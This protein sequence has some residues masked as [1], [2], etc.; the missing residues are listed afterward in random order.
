MPR[1]PGSEAAEPPPP[2]GRGWPPARR[3]ML[4]IWLLGDPHPSLQTAHG[5]GPW[6]FSVL[7]VS[8]MPHVSILWAC[9]EPRMLPTPQKATARLYH[10]QVRALFGTVLWRHCCWWSVTGSTPSVLR[11]AGAVWLN[12]G[13]GSA[14]RRMPLT[15]LSIS[16]CSLMTAGKATLRRPVTRGL[17]ALLCGSVV[18]TLAGGAFD[19][20]PPVRK[21]G[22][23]SGQRKSAP[24]PV[25][26]AEI[27]WACKEVCGNGH[28]GL[29]ITSWLPSGATWCCGD[30]HQPVRALVSGAAVLL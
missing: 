20:A 1:R 24:P 28:L 30:E 23:N 10:C 15:S 17:S 9:A 25:L 19:R 5:L 21:S 3:A 8:Q 11:A 7:V 14:A 12:L 2:C 18:G 6:T 13:S 26:E 16:Q 22:K 4:A 29:R 27:T